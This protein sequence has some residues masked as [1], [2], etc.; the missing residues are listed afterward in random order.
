MV[1]GTLRN[2]LGQIGRLVA[3]RQT[4]ELPDQV[5]LARFVRH[6]E[7]KAFA[8][9]M[10]RH[11]PMVLGVCSRILRNPH[12]AEDA[13]QAVFLVLA[14]QASS[15]R[16]YGS[17]GS[18]LHGVAWRVA[19]KLRTSLSRRSARETAA[20]AQ[21]PRASEPADLSL[22]E[23]LQVLDEELNRL[24]GSYKAPLVLCHLE[25][26]THDEAARELGWTLGALRGRLERG[27]EKLRA[28]LLRRGIT[29]TAALTAATL[30][31]GLC[32]AAVPPSLVVTTLNASGAMAAGQALPAAIPSQ[33]ATLTQ[34][35]LRAQWLTQIT[36][37]VSAGLGAV[38][39]GL[40]ALWFAGLLGN[41]HSQARA[42]PNTVERWSEVS[43]LEGHKLRV[44]C[45]AFSPDGKLIASGAGGLIPSPGELRLWDAA[46]GEVLVSVETTH[47]VRGMAF[48]PDG[49]TLATAEHDG[50]ARLREVKTGKVLHTLRGHQAGIDTV[51]FSPDGKT[52][53]TSSWDRT[54]KLWDPA[55]GKV[56]RTLAG[57]DGSVFAAAFGAGEGTL[58]SGG[59]DQTAR[60]WDAA[61][62]QPRHTLKGHR[63]V[64]HWVA[65]S[66]DGKTLA[67]ASWD[68]TVKL[69]ET[70]TGKPVATL[71]GHDDPVLAVA[72]SPD[73]RTLA[74]CGGKW[75]DRKAP[76]TVPSPGEVIL[77]DWNTHKERAR[78][79]GQQDRVLGLAFSPDGNTLAIAGW[80]RTVKLWKR[81]LFA[82]AEAEPEPEP[83]AKPSPERYLPLKGKPEDRDDL[84]LI[85]PNAN[86]CVRFEAAGLRITLPAGYP[87]ERPNTGVRIPMPTEGDFE[88][89][90]SYEILTEPEQADAGQKPTKLMLQAV[91][92]R[93]DWTVAVLTRRV[94]S[95]MGLQF[96]TWT[97]RSNYEG[98]G[99][100]QTKH[101]EFAAQAKV[102]R[103][104]LVRTGPD[105]SFQIADGPG[106][107][108]VPKPDQLHVGEE[109]LQSIE[110]VGST[111]G[112]KA[113]LDVRF[114]DL[115]V[116]TG[117]AVTPPA[118][119]AAPPRRSTWI[120]LPI[121]AVFLSALALGALLLL[122]R[123]RPDQ[124]E[125][126]A[127][128]LAEADKSTATAPV[129]FRCSGC[130]KG[131]KVRVELAGK[132]I[133]CP[134]CGQVVR[135]P[136]TRPS[137]SPPS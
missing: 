113:K 130:D 64:V 79:R 6:R 29:A 12:D 109:D 19:R 136:Q 93:A 39:V 1:G 94:T 22:R 110:L 35:V 18:W 96:T 4:Q 111:G 55:T 31:P 121:L 81:E 108:F 74:S 107:D 70:A 20:A 87:G 9:L 129:A 23:V 104:R 120:L 30:V 14:R 47:S 124:A 101:R 26:R 105:I 91:L 2:V 17:L 58:A 71:R 98:T 75:A 60:I 8:V 3:P 40:L 106:A 132:K 68:K 5:L 52:L 53:A 112:P 42:E 61:T 123:R 66:P 95:D 102:G 24:P 51:S 90:V 44:W 63:G 122:R 103:L 92:D 69:W 86:R 13:C 89:E 77:W 85:G 117:K 10:E 76:A 82:A 119:P 25:G 48:A 73:G 84:E 125:Q 126:Q 116:R 41:P 133:K 38:L 33:V 16:K 80:D 15:V 114:T 50:L 11:G 78:L 134:G 56:V 97:R 83:K 100:P 57:H 37:A 135:V 127:T 59:I 137:V 43:T 7:E 28:R 21:Q 88:A 32:S 45:V 99:K 36:T 115:R 72:F 118:A 128:D 62:G 46:T 54:V 67:T 27:R 131:I 49:Q 34:E 65:Y